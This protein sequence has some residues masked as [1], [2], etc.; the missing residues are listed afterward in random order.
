M[1]YSK[2]SKFL[3]LSRE[4]HLPLGKSALNLWWVIV[5]L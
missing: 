5:R 1:G 4:K 2:L 3:K